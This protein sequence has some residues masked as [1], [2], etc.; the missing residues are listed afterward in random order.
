[1]LSPRHLPLVPL[2]LRRSPTTRASPIPTLALVSPSAGPHPRP[3]TTL[4]KR[5]DK[6]YNVFYFFNK[7][8][9]GMFFLKRLFGLDSRITSWEL[10]NR[11][12]HQ[13]L[14]IHSNSQVCRAESRSRYQEINLYITFRALKRRFSVFPRGPGGFRELREA[15]R[16]HFE[17]SWYL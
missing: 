15:C 17:L 4:Q 5:V 1:M 7:K 12:R 3:Y 10:I 2:P 8:C 14:P 11:I 9:I 6:E 13:I 16:N